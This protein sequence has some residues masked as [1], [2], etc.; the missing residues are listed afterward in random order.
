MSRSESKSR[1]PGN[2]CKNCL[3]HRNLLLS[4]KEEPDILCENCL[5]NID[6]QVKSQYISHVHVCY[7]G[8]T[9]GLWT[10]GSKWLLKDQPL[11]GSGYDAVSVE[12]LRKRTTIPLVPEIRSWTDSSRLF[13]WTSLV[14]GCTLEEAWS[15]LSEDEKDSYAKEVAGYVKQL[16]DIRSPI[17][18]SVDGQLLRDRSITGNDP[19]VAWYIGATETEWWSDT[20]R[21]GLSNLPP[22]TIEELQRDF[23]SCSPYT[24]THGDLNAQNIMVKNGR[25]MA[26]IDWEMA[27]FYP[28]WYESFTLNRIQNT[29]WMGCLSRHLKFLPD[30]DIAINKF[31]NRWFKQHP[32][33]SK[34][35]GFKLVKTAP[36]CYCRPHKRMLKDIDIKEERRYAKYLKH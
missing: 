10:V 9:R 7:T 3:H 28:V 4:E 16:R 5:W 31:E 27:G 29:D 14:E 34:N 8:T 6:A 11:R 22:Q 1:D 24:F 2:L 21:P 12:Y 32:E 25:V 33:L 23:P 30:S 17:M 36:F 26:I 13:T 35:D 19:S 18:G 15:T 20:L